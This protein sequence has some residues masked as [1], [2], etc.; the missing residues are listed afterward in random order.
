ALDTTKLHQTWLWREISRT[1]VAIVQAGGHQANVGQLRRSL[2]GA[3]LDRDDNSS[4]LAAARRVFLTAASLFRNNRNTDSQNQ[5]WPEFWRGDAPSGGEAL[6]PGME[7]AIDGAGEGAWLQQGDDQRE[8]LISLVRE[9]AGFA[10]DGRRPALIN[11]LVDLRRH[12]GARRLS[13]HLTRLALPLALKEA[14][15]VP[16]S[17]PGLLGGRRLALGMSAA[18]PEAKPLSDWLN[19]GLDDL[20]RE[21]QQSHHRLTELTSQHRAWHGALIKEGLRKHALAPRALDLLAAT[22]VLSIGLVARHLGCSHVA[23]GKIAEKLTELGILIPA[24]SRSRHKIFVAGD[25][26]ARGRAET[27][28][29]QPLVRSEPTPLV[30]VDALSSTLD[31]LFSDLD[32]LNERVD[33]RTKAGGLATAK[34]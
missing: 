28:P 27:D 11:L 18:S 19:A 34:G 26:A 2:I 29:D 24:T 7:P 4:G 14:G 21:A 9:L 30:D 10:D 5:L 8:R 15:L 1:S 33:A 6:Q 31:G 12:A 13:P 20:A 25:L 16:K 17:A 22:P 23:A 32:R 3:P